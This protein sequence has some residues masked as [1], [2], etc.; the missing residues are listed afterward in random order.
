MKKIMIL[1]IS[2]ACLTSCI[3]GEDT[4]L[5]VYMYGDAQLV[6]NG[7]KIALDTTIVLGKELDK[8]ATLVFPKNTKIK[9]DYVNDGDVLIE[10]YNKSYDGLIEKNDSRYD[11]P[12]G[13]F[14]LN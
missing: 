4:V 8:R 12:N 13:K 11:K 10:F 9:Y 14:R 2:L 6:V 5:Q 7:E 1:A 3:K